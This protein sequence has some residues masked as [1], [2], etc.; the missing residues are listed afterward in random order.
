MAKKIM[1]CTWKEQNANTINE[2]RSLPLGTLSNI[3]FFAN[4]ILQS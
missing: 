3:Y 4:I 2:K 1:Y